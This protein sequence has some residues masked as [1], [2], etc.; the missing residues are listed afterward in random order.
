MT[1]VGGRAADMRN[2]NF[3]KFSLV[4]GKY[5]FKWKIIFGI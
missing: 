5:C 3:V 4:D 2:I 1:A